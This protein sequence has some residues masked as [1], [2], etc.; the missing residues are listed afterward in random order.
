[1]IADSLVDFHLSDDPI[2]R[3]RTIVAMSAGTATKVGSQNDLRGE[4]YTNSC[5]LSPDGKWFA[6]RVGSDAVYL[7][8]I[9]R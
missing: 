4:S 7:K 3:H 8:A 9:P 1:M 5:A 6:Y 2:P